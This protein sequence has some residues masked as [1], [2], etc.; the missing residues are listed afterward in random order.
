ME[1]KNGEKG[2]KLEKERFHQFSFHSFGHISLIRAHTH[3]KFFRISRP[4]NYTHTTS[5]AENYIVNIVII[6]AI[7][8]REMQN[9][10]NLII[11]ANLKSA[12]IVA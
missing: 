12:S 4:K 11:D 1:L 3:T 6:I 8:P 9:F 5:A 10:E 7:R 2:V